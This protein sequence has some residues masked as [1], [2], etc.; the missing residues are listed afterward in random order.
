MG[1]FDTSVIEE[2]DGI[3]RGRLLRLGIVL[4]LAMF[5]GRYLG[6]V[7]LDVAILDEDGLN[8]TIHIEVNPALGNFRALSPGKIDGGRL[9]AL[10]VFCYSSIKLLENTEEVLSV[11]LTNIFDAKVVNN[12]DKLGWEPLVA[13]EARGGGGFVVA[14]F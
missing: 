1:E 7:R 2:R 4:Y 5:V 14:I 10:P 13:P 8:V 9:I 11:A 6:L 3:I 12:E